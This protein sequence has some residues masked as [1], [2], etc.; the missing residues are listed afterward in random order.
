V[1][2]SMAGEVYA[3]CVRALRVGPDVAGV[4]ADEPG[5]EVDAVGAGE[6]H[7]ARVVLD[8]EG[9][10]RRRACGCR[11]PRLVEDLRAEGGGVGDEH[12]PCRRTR[13]LPPA[14][15]G[16]ALVAPNVTAPAERYHDV[17][18]THISLAARGC[19]LRRLCRH[20]ACWNEAR[21]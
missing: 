7:A 16:A 17:V 6:G 12:L 2:S 8:D 19:R 18:T 13:P 3:V 10:P 15:P 1:L 20:G 14:V 11:R 21:R 9:S 4:A 5:A